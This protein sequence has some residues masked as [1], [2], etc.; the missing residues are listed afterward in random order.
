MVR[1]DIHNITWSDH[2]PIT[3]DIVDTNK[4]NFAPLWHNNT[5]FLSQPQIKEEIQTKLEEYFLFNEHLGT[6]PLTVW[7]AHK[8]FSRGTLIQIAAREK[9]KK[10]QV[11]SQLH[12]RISDLETKHKQAADHSLLQQLNSSRE[13]LR[14]KLQNDYDIYF[15]TTQ[16]LI[17]F[18]K[19]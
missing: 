2:A 6:H 14:Q 4:T 7:C 13:D 5:Y 18:P 9:R 17:L 10:T 8:A 11:I 1:A 15:K 19:Q 16:T 3:I 12:K